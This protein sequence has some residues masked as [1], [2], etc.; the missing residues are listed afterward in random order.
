MT[1]VT[2]PRWIS[3]DGTPVTGK[4]PPKVQVYGPSGYEL[5]DWQQVDLYHAY[6][7]FCDAVA[8]S[9]YPQL[10]HVQ[11]REWR[12]AGRE[13]V[14]RGQPWLTFGMRLRMESNNSVHRVMVYPI[15]EPGDLLSKLHGIGIAF[16]DHA[17]APFADWRVEV[18]PGVFEPQP[19]IL[20][21][22]PVPGTHRSSGKWQITKVSKLVGGNRVW[23]DPQ[24]KTWI[25]YFQQPYHDRQGKY[26][27][28]W[29]SATD[30]R[31]D[32]I[33]V[34]AGTFEG[35]KYLMR[36]NDTLG[37]KSIE[38]YTPAFYTRGEGVNAVCFVPL[39]SVGG[40]V[41]VRRA[42][43]VKYKGVAET[44]AAGTGY[45]AWS[46]NVLTRPSGYTVSGRGQPSPRGDRVLFAASVS[47]GLSHYE[48]ITNTPVPTIEAG[49]VVTPTS[50]GTLS[51]SYTYTD[52][53]TLP[54]VPGTPW[55]RNFDAALSTAQTADSTTFGPPYYTDEGAIVRAELDSTM[56]NSASGTWSRDWTSEYSTITNSVSA[57]SLTF[58]YASTAP[59]NEIAFTYTYAG[60][61]TYDTTTGSGSETFTLNVDYT[62]REEIMRYSKDGLTVVV[63]LV[64]TATGEVDET[65]TLSGVGA[66]I[67]N[68]FSPS[69]AY[70]FTVPSE[71]AVEVM[72]NGSL[73][74]TFAIGARD[75]QITP[76]LA[77][78]TTSDSSVTEGSTTT[79]TS[80]SATGVHGT[81]S[82]AKPFDP[83]KRAVAR[84]AQDPVT[85]AVIFEVVVTDWTTGAITASQIYALDQ[86]GL[87]TLSDI[88]PEPLPGAVVTW[89][90]YDAN[91]LVTI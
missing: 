62:S 47:G 58:T 81:V 17:G 22:I 87:K 41:N 74:A 35:A 7:L 48:A 89:Q 54:D 15:A 59:T 79:N 83:P 88:L 84:W 68:I 60:S 45:L 53:Y 70:T 57:G 63:D 13:H 31:L 90:L 34:V 56:T 51:G 78:P 91:T 4:V 16:T 5:A 44:A 20:R 73:A 9:A 2:D 32:T 49:G 14:V 37:L 46:S 26:R 43:P 55:P 18:S 52:I 71:R 8:I 10:F 77:G 3:F 86:T 19:L 25:S 64:D 65:V 66:E 42:P 23:V 21:P 69:H 12:H 28:S 33:G 29:T 38:D 76:S 39:S 85:S 6:K 27:E 80:T 1:R 11:N 67:D 30:D 40:D 61:A 36:A 24:R 72:V 50:G 75:I 82:V